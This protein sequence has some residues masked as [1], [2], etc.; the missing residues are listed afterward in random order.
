MKFYEHI[1]MASIKIF[2]YQDYIRKIFIQQKSYLP[3]NIKYSHADNY[4]I[5]IS[6]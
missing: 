3:W 4:G 6:V 2:Q 1:I 5:A